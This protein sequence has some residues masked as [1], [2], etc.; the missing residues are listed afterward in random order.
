MT[1]S[2]DP[3]STA[4]HP[5]VVFLEAGSEHAGQR[6]D[7]FLLARLK[8]V[9]KSRIYRIIRK[10]EVRVN[11][12]RAKPD[13]KLQSGDQ[14]R[15]PPLRMAEPREQLPP[16]QALAG[17]LRDAVLF[18][19]D[20]MVIINKPAGLPVHGGTGVKTGLIEALRHMYPEIGGLEL[21]HRLDKGTSG[22]LLLAK[23][24]RDLNILS[25]QFR[26]GEVRKT[27][28]ALVEGHWP[29]NLGEISKNLRREPARGGDRR[30]TVAP[31]GKAATTHFAVLARY[32]AAS[33]VQA[34]PVTGRT[35]QIRVHAAHAGHA[36]IG[37][38][39]YAQPGS[40]EWFTGQG[41][42]RLCL[43]AAALEL[44]HPATGR[45]LSVQ[46][47]Y[48]DQFNAAIRILQHPAGG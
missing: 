7:N 35:H 46:A 4:D 20:A 11:R 2:S 19:D 38:D 31:G 17:L 23:T 42:R 34:N 18:Q 1:D 43:H 9:P 8:G 29:D 3:G 10:G 40:R 26:Q 25:D 39:K 36:I 45:R 5:T 24:N 15:V 47:P 32:P 6:L 41:I 30:V 22:C 37:D 44:D 28:H 21:V 12:K 33:L 16:S 48:D 14:V 27:Y 13:Y